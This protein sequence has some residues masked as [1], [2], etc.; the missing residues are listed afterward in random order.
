MQSLF[1]PVVVAIIHLIEEQTKAA[2]KKNGEISVRNHYA[3]L[4]QDRRTN[5][6]SV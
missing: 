1:D 5:V 6:A 3:L 4:L 2:K